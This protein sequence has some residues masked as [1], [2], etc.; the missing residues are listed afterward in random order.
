MDAIR[1]ETRF[2]HI[3]H[4]IYIYMICIYEAPPSFYTKWKVDSTLLP[5]IGLDN[6]PFTYQLPFEKGSKPSII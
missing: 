3:V 5:H 6:S 2:I 4:I 1:K